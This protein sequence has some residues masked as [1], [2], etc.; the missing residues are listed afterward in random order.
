MKGKHSFYD[1]TFWSVG[2][3]LVG[4]VMLGVNL[5]IISPDVQ[6]FWPVILVLLG[7][8]GLSSGS[9]EK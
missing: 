2:L 7:L 3:I 8:I 6:R 4:A 5:G 1:M 9:L